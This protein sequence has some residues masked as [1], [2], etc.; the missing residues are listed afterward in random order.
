M[1]GVKL[2][3]LTENCRSVFSF[4][5]S[6]YFL[7]VWTLI[8]SIMLSFSSQWLTS[9]LILIFFT[10]VNIFMLWVRWTCVD[11]QSCSYPVI[12]LIA[13]LFIPS[14]CSIISWSIIHPGCLDR[15]CQ[16]TTYCFPV[17]PVF[18]LTWCYCSHSRPA[19][20]SIWAACVCV[21]VWEWPWAQCPV[22]CWSCDAH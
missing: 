11:I 2:E 16:Q 7:V 15:S 21:C 22:S 20:R 1:L 6:S 3:E 18:L 14:I 9:W 17:W 10:H 12:Y 4:I 5:L 19:Q 13:Q 8:Y